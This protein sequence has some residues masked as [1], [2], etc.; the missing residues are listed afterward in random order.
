[1]FDDSGARGAHTIIVSVNDVPPVGYVYAPSF[2]ATGSDYYDIANAASLKPSRF[3]AAA[4]FKTSSFFSGNAIIVNKGGFGSDSAGEN[5]NYGIWMNE[6]EKIEAGFE[7]ADGTDKFVVSSN[8]YN[9]NKWHYATVTYDGST[10]RLY[11]DGVQVGSLSS[12]SGPDTGSTSS[13]RIG[14]NARSDNLYFIGQIDEVRLWNK[15]LSATEIQNQYK[16]GQFDTSGQ[17]MYFDGVSR[18]V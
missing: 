18:V 13:L 8:S 1:V 7:L 10:V 17:V 6:N 3:T 15:A 4:W 11:I 5:M 9:D 16:L 12:A 14:A 2:D